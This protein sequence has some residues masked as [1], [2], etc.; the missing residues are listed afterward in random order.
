MKNIYTFSFLDKASVYNTL[1]VLFDILY[2]NMKKIAPSASTY[3]QAREEWM[4]Q[5]CPA[6]RKDRRQIILMNHVDILAG[7]AQYYTNDSTLM[8][9]EIQ[10]K[11][12]YQRTR[13]L[14]ELCEF[15]KDAL[16]D[17]LTVIQ[18]YA[19]KRNIASQKLMQSLG[20]KIIKT[21]S[22]F[23]LFEGEIKALRY[24]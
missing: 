8:I 14:R 23:Y 9:E 13:L 20:M 12:E 7:Y 10:L 18:A 19:D 11:P 4:G 15:M 5:V 17:S 1:P 2:L 3:G 22:R 6:M 21:D 16:G 24:V